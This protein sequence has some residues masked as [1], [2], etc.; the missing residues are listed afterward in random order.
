MSEKRM[1]IVNDQLIS[2]IDRHRGIMGRIE[3]V[4][5]CVQATLEEMEPELGAA[6]AAPKVEAAEAEYVTK[7]EFIEF[8]KN[9]EALQREFLN[10]FSTYGRHLLGEALSDDEMKRFSTEFKRLLDL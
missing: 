10:F 9:T 5:R 7:E 2:K 6:E 8:R 1:V 3:F 4:T